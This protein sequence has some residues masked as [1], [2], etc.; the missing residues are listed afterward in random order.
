VA[1]VVA[2][3]A[4]RADDGDGSPSETVERAPSALPAAE[5]ARLERA[6]VAADDHGEPDDAVLAALPRPAT[7]SVST[8]RPNRGFLRYGVTI[9]ANDPNLLLKRPDGQGRFGTRELVDLLHFAAGRVAARFP[10]SQLLVGDLSREGGGRFRPHKSHR[11]GRD[12]DVGFYLLDDQGTY[13][14]P[15][16]FVRIGRSGAGTFEGRR[17]VF[18]LERNWALIE[19]LLGREDV[20]LQ[21]VFVARSIRDRLIAYARAHGA[22]PVTIERASLVLHQPSHGLAHHTHFHVRIYCPLDDRPTCVDVPPLFDWYPR[23]D[24][25]AAPIAFGTGGRRTTSLF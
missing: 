11:T 13:A 16:Q 17:Y 20:A 25:A 7:V 18:D 21:H 5:A 15:P 8:G 9:R 12:A 19:G 14:R 1:A 22:N 10:A 24:P 6:S 23:P 3:R 4:S 2:V